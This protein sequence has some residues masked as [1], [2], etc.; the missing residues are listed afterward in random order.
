[1]SA[2]A[3]W[4]VLGHGAR[5]LADIQDWQVNE[6]LA[7][8]DGNPGIRYIELYNPVGGCLFPSTRVEVFGADGQLLGSA[9]P[10]TFTSCVAPNTYYLLATSAAAEFFVTTADYQIVPALPAAAGQVCFASSTTRYDCVRWGTVSQ[11]VVDFFG[12][13]DMSSTV[14]LA[15][16]QA[17]ARVDTT[18]VVAADWMLASPTPR[19]LNDGTPYTPPDAGPVPDASMGPDA[20]SPDAGLPDAREAGPDSGSL[21]DAA[22][23]PD[24][25]D[26]RF[27]DLDPVGGAACGC[28][29]SPG[30]SARGLLP[31]GGLMLLLCIRVRSRARGLLPA[32][33]RGT[34]MHQTA[35]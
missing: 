9:A 23:Q 16:G 33:A 5:A 17:L 28:R 15:D 13:E 8:A 26:H 32:C 3:F 10:V 12:S 27:L 18:H 2:L 6:V 21:P 11:P 7:S 35:R 4:A 1:M 29:V 14:S 30:S 31:L 22:G 24:A 34:S 20:G 25:R 19:R